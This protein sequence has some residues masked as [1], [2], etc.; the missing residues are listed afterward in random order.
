MY[1]YYEKAEGIL[2][3]SGDFSWLKNDT[4]IS[5]LLLGKGDR[6]TYTSYKS[7]A[8]IEASLGH[9]LFGA[10]EKRF[11]FARPVPLKC[12]I[13]S[14]SADKVFL[15]KTQFVA[16]NGDIKSMICVVSPSDD[17]RY[18]LDALEGLCRQASGGQVHT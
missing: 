17:S 18:L 12:S 5:S 15:Y 3:F 16:A 9:D 2:V 7:R 6:V 1:K 10:V 11:R 4:R 13:V 14:Y 8:E